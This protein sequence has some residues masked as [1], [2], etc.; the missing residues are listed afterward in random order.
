MN[1]FLESLS[2]NEHNIKSIPQN[3]LGIKINAIIKIVYF[4]PYYSDFISFARKIRK[5]KETSRT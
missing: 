5:Q 2:T 3:D 4:D 1:I